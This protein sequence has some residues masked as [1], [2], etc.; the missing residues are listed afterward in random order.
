MK[1][2]D[3]AP[4]FQLCVLWDFSREVTWSDETGLVTVTTLRVGGTKAGCE[5][6][7]LTPEGC[8]MVQTRD[9]SAPAPALHPLMLSMENQQVN[10]I[11]E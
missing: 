9:N 1:P 10:E 6:P 3:P 7:G 11:R 2:P 4:I 5:R 8:S